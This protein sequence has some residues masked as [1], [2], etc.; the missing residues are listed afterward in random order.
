MLSSTLSSAKKPPSTCKPHRTRIP[1][2]TEKSCGALI[3]TAFGLSKAEWM[4]T[5]RGIKKRL[6][7]LVLC[8]GAFHWGSCAENSVTIVTEGRSEWRIV[9]VSPS[10]TVGFAAGELR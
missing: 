5:F 8:L 9:T 3:H 1:D 10:P 7:I 2:E 6:C 4:L